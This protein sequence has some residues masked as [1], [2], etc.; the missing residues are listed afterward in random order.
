MPTIDI[1]ELNWCGSVWGVLGHIFLA[2]LKQRICFLSLVL[3]GNFW[4]D[5]YAW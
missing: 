4:S 1:Q 5:S 2:F 3:A